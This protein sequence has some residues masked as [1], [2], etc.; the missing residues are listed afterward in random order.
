M[1]LTSNA[2]YHPVLLEFLNH[3]QTFNAS[4]PSPLVLRLGSRADAVV[5]AQ[6][7]EL[8][9]E[10][11]G[12]ANLSLQIAAGEVQQRRAELRGLLEQWGN[13]VRAYWDGTPWASLVPNLPAV[14]VAV[15]KFMR[16]FREAL[17]LWELIESLPPPPG[18]PVPLRIGPGDVLG[19]VEFTALV[20]ALR[21]AVLAW[22]QAG[23]QAD[24]ARARRDAS[25]KQVRALLMDYTRALP[26]RVGSESPLLASMPRLWPA[27]GHT[28]EPVTAQGA[29]EPATSTARLTWSASEDKLLDHYEVRACSGPDYTRDDETAAGSVAADADRVLETSAFLPAAGAVASFRVYVVLTTGNERGSEPVVVRR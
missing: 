7:L 25:I 27:P 14:E 1:P 23:F 13:L 22:E 28:P 18:A 19:R 11:V 9:L 3:W 5:L 4:M 26:A 10:G 12:E 8:A 6:D 17:R 21:Q 15:E 2:S 20:E 29:W 24:V 16:P